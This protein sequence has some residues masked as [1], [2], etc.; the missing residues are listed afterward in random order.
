[1]TEL[2]ISQLAKAV[3]CNIRTIERYIALDKVRP[4][5]RTAGGHMRFT[6]D[7]IEE[8]KGW[9]DLKGKSLGLRREAVSIMRSGTAKGRRKPSAYHF[10]RETAAKRR[11]VSRSS[12]PKD[13]WPSLAEMLE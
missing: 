6:E 8:V 4:A 10:A 13:P 9:L 11:I 5:R 1:M 2:R 12:S 7:Q 3:G